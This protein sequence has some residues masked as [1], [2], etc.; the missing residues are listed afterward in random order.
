MVLT[1]VKASVKKADL[2]VGETTKATAKITPEK[3]ENVTFAWASSDK[4]LQR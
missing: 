1:G 2:K 4:K 3:A